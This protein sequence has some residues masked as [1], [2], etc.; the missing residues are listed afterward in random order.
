MKKYINKGVNLKKGG[1]VK[2]EVN[3]I[4]ITTDFY[5]NM[6]RIPDGVGNP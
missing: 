2:G 4:T 5:I 6:D 1:I 3:N